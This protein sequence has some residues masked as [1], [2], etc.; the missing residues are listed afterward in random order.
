MS[1]K[2]KWCI[3]AKWK[4]DQIYISTLILWPPNTKKWLIGKDPD[5]GKDWRQVEKGMTG[6][7]VGWRHWLNGHEFE[8]APGAG[9][10]QGKPGMLQSMGQK[11]SDT[12]EL[13]WLSSVQSM[14]PLANLVI[15][16]IDSMTKIHLISSVYEWTS[17]T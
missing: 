2:T 17:I 9:D 13:N 5:A 16:D 12:T 6:G 3:F 11:E 15:E 14:S 10:G 8:Q 1:L 4:S 7:K